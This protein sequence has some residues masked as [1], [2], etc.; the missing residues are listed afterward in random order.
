MLRTMWV[1]VTGCTVF[2]FPEQQTRSQL[3]DDVYQAG[4]F[5]GDGIG[6]TSAV[7][8]TNSGEVLIGLYDTRLEAIAAIL[9]HH[10]IV[11]TDQSVGI[12]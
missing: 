7:A 8:F 10:S 6:H 2:V 9:R 1:R 4:V 12:R 3:T 11:P 5:R